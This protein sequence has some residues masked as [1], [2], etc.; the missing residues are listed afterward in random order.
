MAEAKKWVLT[1]A[2]MLA[3]FLVGYTLIVDGYDNNATGMVGFEVVVPAEV[4]ALGAIEGTS[5]TLNKECNSDVDCSTGERCKGTNGVS[6]KFCK[7]GPTASTNVDQ[8]VA[9]A[10][11]PNVFVGAML[12][13]ANALI[14]DS[15]SEPG[16]FHEIDSVQGLEPALKKITS[17]MALLNIQVSQLGMNNLIGSTMGNSEIEAQIA[18]IEVKLINLANV[19]APKLANL[20]GDVA[21]VEQKVD[22]ICSILDIR[23]IHQESYIE[24][25]FSTGN[26]KYVSYA[27]DED[28][29]SVC[30]QRHSGASEVFDVA[31]LET[32]RRWAD[33]AHTYSG[34]QNS[35]PDNPMYLVTRYCCPPSGHK[36]E[37]AY[38]GSFVEIDSGN[39]WHVDDPAFYVITKGVGV[40]QSGTRC[41][42]KYDNK[43]TGTQGLMQLSRRGIGTTNYNYFYVQFDELQDDVDDPEWRPFL[44]GVVLDG[45]LENGQVTFVCEAS[46]GDGT[47]EKDEVTIN[48]QKNVCDVW[49]LQMQ[50]YYPEQAELFKWYTEDG[51]SA[52]SPDSYFASGRYEIPSDGHLDPVE[53]KPWASENGGI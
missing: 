37:I 38:A 30:N 50:H 15:D 40:P 9:Q 22:G 41:N 45:F 31:R 8:P 20:E 13:D 27:L 11:G 53:Q 52:D 29:K 49:N 5:T 25:D 36:F 39:G 23:S 43:E 17:A 48:V 12:N 1:V 14:A 33:G 3:V 32:M 34:E 47:V 4:A 7:K 6:E 2:V 44:D 16:V 19:I 51:C 26:M 18:A 42:L 24:G 21:R 46:L 28:W 35:I 10:S